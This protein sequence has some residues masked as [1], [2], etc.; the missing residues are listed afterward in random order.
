MFLTKNSKSPFYQIVYF[1]NGK[2]TTHSTRKTNEQEALQ[3]LKE[4]SKGVHSD[5]TRNNLDEIPSGVQ[6]GR[7]HV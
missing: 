3:Y 5:E 2:R 7:A 4:F 1:V 6:I